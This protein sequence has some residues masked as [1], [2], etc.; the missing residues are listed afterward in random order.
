MEFVIVQK[1]TWSRRVMKV[2][3]KERVQKI[4]KS[5]KWFETIVNFDFRN[6]R[7]RYVSENQAKVINEVLK[8]LTDL[9]WHISLNDTKEVEFKTRVTLEQEIYPVRIKPCNPK[10]ENKTF[11]GI[12]LGEMARGV[13]CSIDKDRPDI[14]NV[15]STHYN[16]AIFVPELGKVIFGYE[17]FWSRIT[18]EEVKEITNSEINSTWYIKALRGLQEVK[19]ED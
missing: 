8:L 17:S 19:H 11:F 12:H 7:K 2:E 6:E 13:S 18:D 14:L 4:K 3:I 16:P 1:E 15:F 5:L 9:D 10:Y